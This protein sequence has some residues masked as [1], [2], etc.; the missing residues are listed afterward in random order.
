[1]QKDERIQL[2]IFGIIYG[3]LLLGAISSI[4]WGVLYG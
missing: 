2:W 3:T 1:M 4:V